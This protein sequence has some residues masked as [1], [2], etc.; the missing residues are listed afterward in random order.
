MT[1]PASSKPYF[2]EVAG[3]WESMRQSFFSEAIRDKAL[4][5]AGIRQGQVAADIGAGS[6]FITAGLVARGVRVIAVDQSDAMLAEMRQRFAEVESIDCRAGEAEALPVDNASVD[7]VFANML[8]HHVEHPAAAI[9]EM[10]RILKPGG[11]LAI[12]DLDEHTFEFLR[13]EQ[14]DRWMGFKRADVRAWLEA[15]GLER[16]Q[17]LNTEES[18][19]ADSSCGTQRADV[20]VFLAVGRKPGGEAPSADDI[21]SAVRD[22]YGAIARRSDPDLA[23]VTAASCCGD[24]SSGASCCA[25]ALYDDA[26]LENLPAD[27]TGLSLGCGDPVTIAG[28]KLGEAVLDLGSGGGIDCFLA[29]R[30]V[31]ESGHVIGVDMTPDMLDK[32]NAAKARMGVTNVEFRRGQI[33]A[34]PVDD[35]TIDVVTSN[36]VINL[37]P[38]KRAVFAE[39][40]R[41]L[42]PGG[43][44]SISDVVTEGA[45]PDGLPFDV[46]SWSACVAG[47]IDVNAYLDLMREVGFVDVQA[48]DKTEGVGGEPVRPSG[49]LRVYS[50]RITGRKP[51]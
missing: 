38:D 46:L 8:L 9:A 39:S 37:S 42:K 11:V 25:P 19:C 32:A 2:D 14:H 16:A 35:A 7:A 1:S 31:G 28:L 12:T 33:E 5:A 23:V 41:V 48:V 34:L 21:H 22:H 50:A 18:C 36:C 10:A 15:A 40:F 4:S 44:V 49:D 47:A 43:R 45:G 3:Q 17:V 51:A 29:A 30:Q 6:G 26:L 27:V 20:S 13:T 24:S